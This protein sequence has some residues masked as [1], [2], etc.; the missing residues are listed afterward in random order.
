[1]RSTACPDAWVL[2]ADADADLIGPGL[3]TGLREAL[4]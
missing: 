4:A 2:D 3:A 1:M